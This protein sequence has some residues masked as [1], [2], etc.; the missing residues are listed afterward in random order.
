MKH[1]T[2][3]SIIQ[4]RRGIRHASGNRFHVEERTDN[5]I[6]A[7]SYRRG[8]PAPR[9]RDTKYRRISPGNCGNSPGCYLRS[10]SVGPI[11]EDLDAD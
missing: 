9:L 4:A 8:C 6:R 1:F 2:L 10:G 5:L 7:W 11:P 3:G